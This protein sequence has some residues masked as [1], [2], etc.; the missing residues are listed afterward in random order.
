M[1]FETKCSAPLVASAVI[2]GVGYLAACGTTESIPAR[3]HEELAI[4]STPTVPPQNICDDGLPNYI[5]F[6]HSVDIKTALLQIVPTADCA[7]PLQPSHSDSKPTN[8]IIEGTTFW[9]CRSDADHLTVSV[10][11][12][13]ANQATAG[14]VALGREAKEQW[15]DSWDIPSCHQPQD[16]LPSLFNNT[17]R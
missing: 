16:S 17:A 8:Y 7:T 3:N 9:A 12:D 5:A 4:T 15:E 14:I 6:T 13:E 11:A 1:K 10:V 2:F